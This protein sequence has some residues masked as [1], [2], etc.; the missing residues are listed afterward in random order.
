MDYSSPP[1]PKAP[2]PKS[3]YSDDVQYYAPDNKPLSRTAM[4]AGRPVSGSHD[5]THMR[6]SDGDIIVKPPPSRIHMAPGLGKSHQ[7]PVDTEYIKR[8][9]GDG[10]LDGEKPKTMGALADARKHNSGVVGKATHEEGKMPDI[11]DIRQNKGNSGTQQ[12]GYQYTSGPKSYNGEHF[13][14][15]SS[16]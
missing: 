15:R 5:H 14:K 4:N 13:E 2:H 16:G 3:H 8:G 7:D 12:G 11:G 10:I 6:A 9:T 1:S